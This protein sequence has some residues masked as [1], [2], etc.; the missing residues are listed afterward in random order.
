MK[1]LT[2]FVVLVLAALVVGW[3]LRRGRQAPQARPAAPP[4]VPAPRRPAG[5][6][7]PSGPQA[8]PAPMPDP[9]SE[10][11]PPPA[12]MPEA[13]AAFQWVSRSSLS[14]AR[15]KAI[16]AALQRLPAPSRALHQLVAPDFLAQ[17]SSSD[18][19]ELIQGEPQ[20][21]AKVLAT[22]NSPLFGLQVP[23][24]S[25]GP[26]VTYLG[27]NTVRGICLRYMLEDAFPHSDPQVKRYFAQVWGASTLASELCQRLAPVGHQADPGTLS[28]QVLLSFLGRLA[29]A[30]LLPTPTLLA[31]AD[32]DL[33]SRCQREQAELGLNA[34]EVGALLMQSW[35]L[36]EALIHSTQE[37]DRLL[38]SPPHPPKTKADQRRALTYLSARLG[39]RLM[40]GR[41]T[42]AQAQAL[43]MGPEAD[44]HH[45]QQH[46][47][48][49]TL[50]G[51]PAWLATAD[52]QCQIGQMQQRLQAELP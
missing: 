6:S 17:A 43:V 40:W 49:P 39:E 42:P 12:P 37:I 7:S 31:L 34:S 23:V 24:M 2:V 15:Q 47:H 9:H 27:L 46:L 21:A 4:S 30:S 36:P 50:G 45:L 19:A 41:A 16:M 22:V 11:P 44:F 28:T 10:P 52:W 14:E 18:L 26:A 3:L 38:I 48:G 25:I 32:Q 1:F 35:Q 5:S 51:V 33:L 8:T 29:L 13:L 20:V